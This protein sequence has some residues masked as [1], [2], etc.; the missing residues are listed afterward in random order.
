MCPGPAIRKD[1][2]VSRGAA[3]PA[4]APQPPLSC[5]PPLTPFWKAVRGWGGVGM[6]GGVVTWP[7]KCQQ[8][9]VGGHVAWWACTDRWGE[10]RWW[11]RTLCVWSLCVIPG[12]IFTSSVHWWLWKWP[13][14]PQ[15]GSEEALRCAHLCFSR[16]CGYLLPSNSQVLFETFFLPNVDGNRANTLLLSQAV[17]IAL[18]LCIGTSIRYFYLE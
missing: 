10:P 11:L 6:L 8:G 12:F 13:P 17:R 15:T 4:E 16:L 3:N 7:V 9:S 14:K 1:G 2:Q 18:D 5:R